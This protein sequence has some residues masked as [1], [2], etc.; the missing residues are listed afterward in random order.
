MVSA[1][2]FQAITSIPISLFFRE[3]DLVWHFSST[4]VYSVKSGYRVAFQDLV[5]PSS[6]PSSSFVPDKNMWATIWKLDVPHK[7]R[8]FWWRACS[9]SLATKENLVRRR[10]GVSKAC[11]ICREAEESIEHL[12]FACQW[13]RA[14][15]FGCNV[16]LNLNQRTSSSL[17]RWTSQVVENLKGEE[18]RMKKVKREVKEGAL[19][20]SDRILQV[21]QYLG[22]RF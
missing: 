6:T 21:S 4:G 13:V 9:N 12:V 17:Q 7:M 16:Q 1:E 20:T 14:V 11:P 5:P 15:W 19:A 2:D 10:C 22:T 18:L 8:H 3:D